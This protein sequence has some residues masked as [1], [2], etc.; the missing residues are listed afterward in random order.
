MQSLDSFEFSARNTRRSMYDYD[1]LLDGRIWKMTEGV[2]FDCKKSSMVFLI[3]KEAKRRNIE[4]KVANVPDGIVL[5]AL[6][7]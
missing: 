4:V 6:V 2:D 1:T 3:R 7:D 5:Q